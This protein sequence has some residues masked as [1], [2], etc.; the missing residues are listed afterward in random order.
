M[1]TMGNEMGLTEATKP[2]VDFDAVAIFYITFAAVWTVLLFGGMAFLTIKR[3]TP[4]LQIRGLPLTF[5]AIFFLHCYWVIVQIG[6]V[7]RPL[8]PEQVE[9]W[10]MGIELPFGIGLFQAANTQFLHV[11]KMQR[12]YALGGSCSD[13]D[14]LDD[15]LY[16]TFSP[17]SRWKRLVRRFK[18]IRYSTRAFIIVG[19]LLIIQVR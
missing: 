7:T 12:R 13:I 15:R 10:V 17:A 19:F 4:F 1:G 3:H 5:I 14:S 8:S 2:Q 9:Y 11:A 18:K 16:Q 6:Y